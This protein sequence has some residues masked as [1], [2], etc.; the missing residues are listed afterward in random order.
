MKPLTN[1]RDAV[2]VIATS[3]PPFKYVLRRSSTSPFKN[4]FPLPDVVNV[5]PDAAFVPASP[6]MGPSRCRTFGDVTANVT[7]PP[8]GSPAWFDRWI[9]PEKWLLFAAEPDPTSNVCP[10][11]N[12]NAE[13]LE[14]DVP[15]T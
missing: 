7:T 6:V 8:P 14:P 13:G 12:V 3:V 4:S 5:A 9:G 1:T 10:G 11:K 15:Q 2:L